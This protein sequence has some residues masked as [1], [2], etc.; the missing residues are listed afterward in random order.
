MLAIR[1]SEKTEA[2]LEN[3]AKKTG[4]TKTYYARKAIEDFLEEKEEYL[5]A[6]AVLEKKN[7][8]LSLKEVIEKF[9]LES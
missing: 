1:L 7:P 8:S 6:V 5:L 9:D 4:R 2:H 3:L